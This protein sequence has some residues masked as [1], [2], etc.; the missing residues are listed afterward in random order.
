MKSSPL[1][2]VRTD[3][4]DLDGLAEESARSAPTNIVYLHRLRPEVCPERRSSL[5]GKG[6]MQVAMLSLPERADTSAGEF[7]SNDCMRTDRGELLRGGECLLSD[8]VCAAV[9]QRWQLQREN[10]DTCTRRQPVHGMLLM[11]NT[12][13][14]LTSIAATGTAP[15]RHITHPPSA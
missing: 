1:K 13:H 11:L 3:R 9:P 14:G 5:L 4:S 6:V 15:V 10:S 8:R 2:A 12:H 7:C